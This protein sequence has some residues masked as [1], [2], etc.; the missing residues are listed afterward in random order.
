MLLYVRSIRWL[1]L[2]NRGFLIPYNNVLTF[3]IEIG[4]MQMSSAKP[5]AKS[6]LRSCSVYLYMIRLLQHV[7]LLFKD[8]KILYHALCL[9]FKRLVH[10]LMYT[11]VCVE[12]SII[13]VKYLCILSSKVHTL[14]IVHNRQNM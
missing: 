14:Q 5:G 7:N 3:Y 8:S 9:Y 1:I 4:L 13:S 6:D 11:C 10:A 2:Y 12:L